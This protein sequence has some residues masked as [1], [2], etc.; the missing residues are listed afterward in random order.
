M[1]RTACH[2]SQYNNILEYC[3]FSSDH[4][5]ISGGQISMLGPLSLHLRDCR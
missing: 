2:Q 4:S 5:Q 3:K 1:N